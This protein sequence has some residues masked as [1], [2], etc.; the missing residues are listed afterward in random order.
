MRLLLVEDDA[1][2]GDA[3]RAGLTQNGFT[4]D[5]VQDG[6][7]A[8]AAMGVEPFDLMVLD[9]MLP[10]RSGLEV[11]RELRSRGGA[12]PVLVLTARD[13]VADRVEGLDS[14]ADD[15]LVKPFDLAELCARVRALLRRHAGRASPQLV[16]GELVVDP[17]AHTVLKDGGYVDL[18][19]R[20]FALLETLL[21][22]VGKVMSRERLEQA[23][24]GWQAE[25]ES[26]AV[27]VHVH[28]LRKKLGNQLIR[29]IRGVGY[30]IE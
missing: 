15:Y 25:V 5:W 6:E 10:G 30:M 23:V 16:H 29:T 17:A 3:V 12:L 20:E 24:Y 9:I 4:V 11:L 22:N 7:S 1:Q 8:T 26:N 13:T 27:E 14:G 18:S 28:H 19:R 2:L 21:E